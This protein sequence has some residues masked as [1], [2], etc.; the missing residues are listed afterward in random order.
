[1]DQPHLHHSMMDLKPFMRY[2]GLTDSKFIPL[3]Q[4][5]HFIIYIINLQSGIIMNHLLR[6]VHHLKR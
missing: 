6:I 5:E 3:L 4:R 2:K 1:M